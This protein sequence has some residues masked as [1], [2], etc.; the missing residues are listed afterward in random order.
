MKQ[1][2]IEQWKESH[3]EA[4]QI[5]F[6]LQSYGH[7]VIV[8]WRNETSWISPTPGVAYTDDKAVT[9]AIKPKGARN[10][11]ASITASLIIDALGDLYNILR[12]DGWTDAAGLIVPEQE[13]TEQDEE[14]I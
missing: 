9:V 6:R 1:S 12:R 8:E 4:L 5:I 11:E 13:S 7:G 10:Y 3:I 2:A 14:A